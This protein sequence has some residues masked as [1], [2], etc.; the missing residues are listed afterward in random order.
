MDKPMTPIMEFD[1]PFL[2][3]MVKIGMLGYSAQKIINVLDIEDKNAFLAAFH[4][5]ASDIAKAYQKGLDKADFALDIQLFNDAKSGDL[6][7]FVLFE[8]RKRENLEKKKVED[9][10]NKTLLRRNRK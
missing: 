2:R 8:E 6:K 1:E 4:D 9:I 5:T 10:K 3:K 7:A